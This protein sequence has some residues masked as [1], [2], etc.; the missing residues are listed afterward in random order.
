M[1]KSLFFTKIFIKYFLLLIALLIISITILICGIFYNLTSFERN[2][3]S[4]YMLFSRIEKD[5]VENLSNQ[6]K[7]FLNEKKIWMLVL[8]S[9]GKFVKSYYA[10]KKVQHDYT[11]QDLIRETRWYLEGFPSFTFIHDKYI[12]IFGYPPNLYSKYPDNYYN[13]DRFLNI[14][15]LILFIVIFLIVVIFIIYYRSNRKILNEIVP[16]TNAILDLSVDRIVHLE[17]RG[18]LADIKRAL[19]KTSE[20]LEESK[21]EREYWLRGISHD[22]RTPL[23]MIVGYSQVLEKNIGSSRELDI[24]KNNSLR[25]QNILDGLNISYMLENYKELANTNKIDLKKL[26]RKISVDFINDHNQDIFI[27]N[28]FGEGQYIVFGNEDL[29][30][31]AFRNIILNSIKHNDSVKIK[32][33]LKSNLNHIIIEIEDDGS[34]TEEKIYELN[35]KTQSNDIHGLGI[36]IVKKIIKLH[37]G[38]VE[39]YYNNPGLVCLITLEKYKLI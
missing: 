4:P 35:E 1:K 11:H 6:N 18:N 28:N 3:V 36:I 24:I 26:L 20:N 5:K 23:T 33:N 27:D 12:L 31:R 21:K 7:V 14:F 8:D 30:D 25:M 29:L 19:N 32:I 34:I 22:L 13:V 2:S 16:L 10:P 39:F 15:K 9:K 38:N 17:E 37:K